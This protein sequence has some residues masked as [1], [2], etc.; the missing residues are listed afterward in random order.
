MGGGNLDVVLPDNA[1]NLNVAA[2]TGAGNVTVEIG[3]GLAGS[4]VV[5]ANSGAGNV[6]V[7]LPRGV[8]ARIHATVGLGKATVDP[9]FGQTG[10]DTYQTAD[11]DSAVDKVELTVHSGAGNVVVNT[12]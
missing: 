4:S 11:F 12:R 2:K 9:Q 6:V 3:S 5:T 8:A 10:R 1:A 7:C